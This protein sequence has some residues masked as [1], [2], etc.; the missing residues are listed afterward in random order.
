MQRLA[1]THG[2]LAATR[3]VRRLRGSRL[4][5]KSGRCTTFGVVCEWIVEEIAPMIGAVVDIRLMSC[6][7]LATSSAW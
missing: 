7:E 2:C 6:L 1:T 3:M 5:G 4:A